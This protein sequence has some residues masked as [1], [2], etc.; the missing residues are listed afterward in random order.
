[1]TLFLQDDY[2][3]LWNVVAFLFAFLCCVCQVNY[4]NILHVA[5]KMMH[6]QYLMFSFIASSNTPFKLISV[7]LSHTVSSVLVP[8][9]PEEAEILYSP[10]YHH[11]MQCISL[12]PEEHLAAGLPHVRGLPLH[13]AHPPPQTSGQD[14]G[15]WS[16]RTSVGCG[17]QYGERPKNGR[18]FPCD[19]MA[20]EN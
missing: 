11:L 3:G 6:L 5:S 8:Y 9:L 1:M 12:W 19:V 4:I 10:D 20:H 2:D 18:D 15:L 13:A 16:M 14:H 7:S 17:Q